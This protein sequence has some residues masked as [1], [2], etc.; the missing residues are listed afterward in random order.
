MC[1]VLGR[2][3]AVAEVPDGRSVGFGVPFYD[4][5]GIALLVGLKCVGQAYDACTDNNEISVLAFERGG[6]IGGVHG[7]AFL[8]AGNG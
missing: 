2:D 8:R 1:P 7:P 5:D 3:A 4:P 6:L